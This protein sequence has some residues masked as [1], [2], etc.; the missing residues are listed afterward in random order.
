MFVTAAS[1]K[2]TFRRD[3]RDWITF[4][5]FAGPNLL[6]F[7]IF[8]YYPLIRNF[9]LSFQEYNPIIDKGEWVGFNNYVD[10][11]I[12]DTQM[13]RIMQNTLVFTVSVVALILVLGLLTALLLNQKL[14]FRN[15]VRSMLFSPAVLAGSAVAV[16]WLYIFDYRFGLFFQVLKYFGI[17]SPKWLLDPQWAMISLIIVYV[18]K[19]LGYATVIYIAGLQAIPADLYEAA[20]VDGAGA[21]Q[22]FRNVTLPGLSPVTFFLGVTSVLNSFQSFEIINVLTRGGPVNATNV[23]VY[24]LYEQGFTEIQNYGRASVVAT[25]LFVIMFI[26]T[27]I[28]L[29]AIERRVSYA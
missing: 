26:L 28:Q 3:W 20:R 6:L 24:R 15:G 1:F 25:L 17:N 14:R 10:I 23:L 16:I 19:N 2:K 21:W 12:Q 11:L 13:T 8:T 7:V 18:W 22:R 9:L 27:L 29:R 4:V 5:L